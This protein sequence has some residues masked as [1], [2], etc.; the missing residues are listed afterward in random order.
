MNIGSVHARVAV[1]VAAV[2]VGIVSCLLAPAPVGA[3][4]P[5][6]APMASTPSKPMP[7]G[8]TLSGPGSSFTPGDRAL[9]F[10]T[11][12]SWT[13]P[14]A[15][16]VMVGPKLF[17][18]SIHLP[19]A[20]TARPGQTE[21]KS[22]LTHR[23]AVATTSPSAG[24]ISTAA[25]AGL[26]PGPGLDSRQFALRTAVSGSTIY[27]ADDDA[28]VIWAYDTNTGLE[29]VVAGTGVT[30][31]S[32]D[33]GQATAATLRYPS[34][35]NVDAAGNL[36]VAD[37]GNNVIRELVP[38]TG[39]ITTVVGT[40][41]Q[42]NNPLDVLPDAYGNLWIADS[43]NHVIREV[44]AAGKVTTAYSNSTTTYPT[45]LGT[46]S[47]LAFLGGNLL[48]ADPDNAVVYQ[49]AG[50]ALTVFAGNGK[51]GFSG[52]GGP[53]AAAAL[54]EPLAVSTTTSGDVYIADTFNS[55]IRLV[56]SGV[57]SSLTVNAQEPTSVVTS[58]SGMLIASF[59]G[60]LVSI[61]GSV[62][63]TLAGSS[64]YTGDSGTAV[65]AQAAARSVTTDA[66]GLIYLT[67][68]SASRNAVGVRQ[69][70]ATGTISTVASLSVA[71]CPN[72]DANA[73]AVAPDGS[74]WMDTYNGLCH[75]T[76][77]TT[78]TSVAG[79]GSMFDESPG[80]VVTTNG[81]VYATRGNVLCE[82]SSTGT[83]TTR[84][85]GFTMEGLTLDTSGNLWT[86]TQNSKSPGSL[87]LMKI[88][89][90]GVVHTVR[91]LTTNQP[92]RAGFAY[93]QSLVID[94][95]GDIFYAVG[96]D[97]LYEYPVN[98]YVST[99]IAG[100][101]Y[102][103]NLF[104]AY[105]G[106]IVGQLL[107][108]PGPNGDG[109]SASNA[110]L[111][112]GSITLDNQGNLFEVEGYRPGTIREITAAANI[113]AANSATGPQNLDT[114]P[115]SGV[116]P[117]EQ[118][119]PPNPSEVCSCGHRQATANPV[120]TSSGSFW[121]T[122]TDM[123]V[124]GRGPAVS[125]NRTYDSIN[126]NSDGLFGFGWSTPYGMSL[127]TDP[128]TGGVE[129]RQ[130]NGSVVSFIDDGQQYQPVHARELATLT[131]SGGIY[132]FTRRGQQTFNFSSA[133][134]MTAITDL[135][136]DKT[137]LSYDGSGHL[138]GITDPA[139]RTFAVTTTNGRITKLGAPGGRTL[140]YSYD[141]AG[142]LTSA[143][144]PAS[145]KWTYTYDASHRLL[146]MLDPRQ[147][148]ASTP[149]PLTNIYDAQGHVT[150]QTDFAGRATLFDYASIPGATKTTDP[151]GDITVDYYANG[152]R[153]K[154]TTGYG[155][156]AAATTTYTYDSITEAPATVTDPLNHTSSY[157][158]DA[159]G[160]LLTITDPLGRVRTKTYNAL[161][162]TLTDQ[163]PKGITTNMTY[164][165]TGNL[166]TTTT[167]LLSDTGST[168]AT[169][170]VTY[171]HGDSSH[172]GDVTSVTNPNGQST[173]LAYDN[174]GDL[175]S[176][177]APPSPENSGGDKTTYTYNTNTGWRLTQVNPKGNAA[178]T[179]ATYTTTYGYDADGRPNL[180]R[181]SLWTSTAPTLH[182]SSKTFDADG[183]VVSSVDANGRNTTYVYDA[184]G[185]LITANL[186]NGTATHQSWSPD[187]ELATSTDAAGH[188]TRNT[189]NSV[190]EL[191][192][193]L[194]PLNH[195]TT[196][197]YDLAGN[198]TMRAASGAT[199]TGN[200]P[201]TGCV[202]G[203]YDAANELTA[204]AYPGGATPNTT[205]VSYDADGHRTGQTDAAGTS[206]AAYDS[207]GRL[208]AS[209]DGNGV[210][211][212]YAYD[213][214]GNLT[215]LSYPG[216]NIVVRKF[217]SL[218]RLSSVTDWLSNTTNFSYDANSNPTSASL[219]AATGETD[220]TT[221]NQLDQLSTM[222]DS[223]T[224][225]GTTSTLAGFSYGH[226]TA[227]RIASS[228]TSGISEPAQTYTYNAL[229]QLTKSGPASTPTSYGYDSTND[230]VNRG[231]T[232][233][234]TQ[235]FNAGNELCW[236]TTTTVTS[237]NCATTPTGATRYSY[238]NN[239]NR[240]TTTQATGG[241]MH[242]T[243]D[244]AQQLSTY[245]SPAGT[246]TT[247]TYDG[248]GLRQSKA[249]NG[250]TT[251]FT[252]EH[253]DG[254]PLLLSDGSNS[255]LYGVGGVPLEQISST[256][257]V[258]W[259]HHDQL[260]TTRLLTNN[261]GVTVG[262]ATYDAYGVKTAST[263]TMNT[264]LGYNG[265]YTDTESGL[266][267]LRARYYDPTT[268]QFL[269][270]DP[271]VSLTRQPY[272][273]VANDPL[274]GIDPLGLWGWNPI[275]DLGQ[276]ASAVGGGISSAA[277]AVEH[278][279]VTTGTFVGNNYGTLA[280]VGAGVTC[281]V[282]PELCLAAI[283]GATALKV[284][285]DAQKANS[286]GEFLQQAAGDVALAVVSGGFTGVTM[287]LGAAAK[288][289]GPVGALLYP[290]GADYALRALGASGAV[291]D[292]IDLANVLSSGGCAS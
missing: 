42:L 54:N 184:D 191:T 151:V 133:G 130:E 166:L 108:V 38:S 97:E 88:T 20:D 256:G 140:L 200:S 229:E 74:V 45:G 132:T 220:T 280:E 274:N 40:S 112:G 271:A 168:L 128:G 158:Y 14:V 260:G 32:G 87:I 196:Y 175:V 56:S 15:P 173:A 146:T 25:G 279:A 288:E 10:T 77:T 202:S 234:R 121:H 255:Y 251:H 174:F 123:T 268:A 216:G 150:K 213:L 263:G 11:D 183:N 247:Y 195:T 225:N 155:T 218:D 86:L 124:P 91:V 227:G 111:S 267:Y 205:A 223:R 7:Q 179:P 106:G 185:E 152:L 277:T 162:D 90:D 272:A 27:A 114:Y 206:T 50:S 113:G 71:N 62:E 192:S 203:T 245:T 60:E 165:S 46:P 16:P 188:V 129:I 52:N 270:V 136:G 98:G 93:N 164:D 278:A 119:G 100:I 37:S 120:D 104:G 210:A 53:A 292:T 222:T 180:T 177:T 107:S 190:H 149:V 207:L 122:F 201:S 230:V 231:T 84:T 163:D 28:S 34:G 12:R 72:S 264:P 118:P 110:T 153:S 226:D 66:N 116:S 75:S 73:I 19:T 281:V 211:T 89:T 13:E 99:A 2:A 248:G 137:N 186:A 262:T 145:A 212:N 235:T 282:Q 194:D 47:G 285:Q 82:V 39:I 109:A 193:R 49:L 161:N 176:S 199:C 1:V 228:N 48:I 103:Q 36:F 143:T 250:S 287:A 261:N 171:T 276:A 197:S 76:S 95:S 241:A 215:S 5:P 44:N 253:A 142:N 131:Y 83:V 144:D 147:Q 58:P 117:I 242:Y 182:Q 240:T 138:N 67:D 178:G 85:L 265:Q 80:V 208:T 291:P 157:T 252:W 41:A 284:T 6:L 135:N 101:G 17:P 249:T 115:A 254:V 170:T 105:P 23:T 221:F 9:N 283:A 204:Q 167:P 258:T 61:S 243:Y 244:E 187:G 26:A 127:Q 59:A 33:G 266:I 102:Q 233:D 239:G 257:A 290:K 94:K 275:S 8:E 159:S 286:T 79:C 29:K 259:L 181:D 224:V 238:D 18:G 217:D 232:S 148:G 24:T 273:Y 154:T 31:Y 92:V 4:T 22:P 65:N 51:Q 78:S 3:A 68:F 172:P 198:Q 55:A 81:T 289:A 64:A 269:T 69:I 43:G 134:Q 189:Y 139:G 160:N 214:D 125:V 96:D 169:Q 21:S 236:A 70:S 219:P 209:T 35:L 63:T 156:T 30:G 246:S 126:T 237:P 57:I 141:T